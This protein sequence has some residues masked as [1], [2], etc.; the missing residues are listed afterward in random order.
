[1]TVTRVQRYKNTLP[2]SQSPRYI[3]FGHLPLTKSKHR[4]IN[5]GETG[6]EFISV[7]PILGR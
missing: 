3:K 4:E 5:G 6:R 1:M 7:R 2:V